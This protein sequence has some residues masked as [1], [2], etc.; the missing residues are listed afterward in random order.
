MTELARR[1]GLELA[2]VSRQDQAALARILRRMLGENDA[3]TG[4]D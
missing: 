4:G 3:S 2:A 1:E